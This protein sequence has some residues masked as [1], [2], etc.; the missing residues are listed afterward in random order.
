MFSNLKFQTKALMLLLLFAAVFVFMIL[1]TMMTVR[2][3]IIVTAHEKLRSDMALSY[4]ML[5]DKYPGDWSLKDGKLFKGSVQMNENYSAIDSIA[6]M[7]KDSVTIFQGDTRIATTVKNASGER[8]VGTKAAANIAEA[9]IHKGQPYIGRA[10]VVGTWYQTAYEPIKDNKGDVIGIFYVG[11]PNTHYDRVVYEI[12][13]K[14]VI[15]GVSSLIIVFVLGILIVRSITKPI[16][17]VIRG[18]TEGAEHVAA[19]SGKVASSS[20]SLAEGASAQAASVEETSSSLAEMSSMTSNNAASADQAKA[21]MMEAQ[22]IVARVSAHMDNMAKAVGEVTKTSEE[23]GKIIKTIDEIAFQTNLLALNAAVEAARAGEA[24]AGFAVVAEE[25][26]NLA[27]RAA[28]AARNTAALIDN[29]IQVARKNN[30]IMEQTQ[31]AFQEN[32]EISMKI[33]GI[34][35]EISAASNE[36]AQGIGQI[37]KAVSEMDKVMQGTAAHAEE[38]ASAS[39][40]LSTQAEQMEAFVADLSILVSGKREMRTAAGRAE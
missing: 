3:K 19:A 5:N 39:E 15:F 23:T 30:Q 35:E 38:S 11:V 10:N 33:G 22:G 4:A 40:E 25:V 37:N 21:H 28:D 17:R 16:N 7:S 32:V 14:V 12:M 8:A 2:E 20:Q 34:I 13:M 31:A 1:F 9:V 29:T 36:Q 27:M 18:L 24:G 26:R 6:E